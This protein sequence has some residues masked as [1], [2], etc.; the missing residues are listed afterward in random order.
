MRVYRDFFLV[1]GSRSTF[2]DT[3]PDPKHCMNA[4]G[5]AQALVTSL[6]VDVFLF[7]LN[8]VK[9]LFEITINPPSKLL[10]IHFFQ[11]QI[12]RMSCKR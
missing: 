1:P 5:N 9:G 6:I 7:L 11:I 10:S 8:R 12:P 4:Y 3:D 2:P